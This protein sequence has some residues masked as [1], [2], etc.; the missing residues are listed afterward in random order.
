M[1]RHDPAWLL[2]CYR[3]ERPARPGLPYVEVDAPGPFRVVKMAEPFRLQAVLQLEPR[4]QFNEAVTRLADYDHATRTLTLQKCL[5]S[6][7]MKS[8]YAMEQL[9]ELFQ[10]EYGHRLPP[11]TD[12]RLSNGIGTAVVVFTPAGPYLPRRARGQAVFPRGYH[13][14]AS[15]EAVWSDAK[16]FD[17]IFTANICRELEEEV[18]LKRTDLDWVRPVAF[19]RE[20]LRGGKPQFFFTGFTRLTAEELAERR[21]AAIARQIAAGLQ[22][23]E[24]D[25]A[26]DLS[27]LTVEAAANL[28]FSDV[29]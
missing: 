14:T 26:R 15:G 1:L 3:D 4:L 16:G 17:E 28:A 8:N 2:E 27:D 10:A 20:F 23:I 18:G 22:E 13:C 29:V 9:R 12:A 25:V 7:G 24:D 21:R 5:Y 11:L 6:D 19:C